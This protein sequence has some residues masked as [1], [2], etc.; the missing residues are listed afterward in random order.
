MKKILVTGA[1]GLLGLNMGLQ[2]GESMDMVGQ[3][4]QNRLQNVPF[5]QISVDLSDPDKT[6]QMMDEIR[7][8]VLVHCTAMANVDAC[9][10]QFELA[11]RINAEVPGQLAAI[12]KHM[13][14]YMVH[15]STDAVFDGTKGP[16][17]EEDK[18]NPINA[19][20]KTKLAGEEEVLKNNEDASILRV[21]FF[22]WSVTG[23]R[24]LAEFFANSFKAGKQVN[25]FTDVE[26]CP[27]M[28]NDLVDVIE[29][30]IEKKLKGLY[31][32]V[33]KDSLSKYDFGLKIARKFGYDES[34]IEP[35]SWKDGNLTA[36][37]SPDLRL[38][39][40]KLAK[41]LGV[42]LPGVNE[43]IERFYQQAVENYPERIMDCR[44]S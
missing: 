44:I 27:M 6:A 30:V 40:A 39:T 22:G 43:G 16:Y 21:N 18:P 31:H 25:G 2:I 26:F 15:I 4:N 12:C 1:S 37:R 28:V 41:S 36:V 29:A 34:L 11:Q 17:S 13:G 14:T 3:V 20:A 23:K 38:N 42:V 8:E 24:S 5:K 7:P 33:G 10:S 32:A 19:Y 35:K 9:E